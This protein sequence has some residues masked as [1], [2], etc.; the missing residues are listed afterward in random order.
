MLKRTVVKIREFA[1]SILAEFNANGDFCWL[2]L[3]YV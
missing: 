1:P 3:F 2:V